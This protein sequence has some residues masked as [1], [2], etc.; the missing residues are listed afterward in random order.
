MVSKA[1]ASYPSI[2][3]AAALV[4]ENGPR[5]RR[6]ELRPEHLRT[7]HDPDLRFFGLETSGPLGVVETRVVDRQRGAPSQLLASAPGRAR[8]SGYRDS[9]ATKVITPT[10]RSRQS[11]ART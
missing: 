7:D 9:A 5:R 3:Q 11:S 2:R 6:P 10:E 1:S 8:H 4:S